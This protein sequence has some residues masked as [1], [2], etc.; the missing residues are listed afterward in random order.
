VVDVWPHRE[1]SG[2]SVIEGS[3]APAALVDDSMARI[4][5]EPARAGSGSRVA[6]VAMQY[7]LRLPG[8]VTRALR[9]TRDI[10]V[11]MPDGAVLLADHWVPSRV[12]APLPTV[13]LRSPYG[14]AGVFDGLF[15]RPFAERGFQVVIQSCRGTYGSGGEFV[16]FRHE[17]ADGATTI[18]WIAEQ[19]WFDGTLVL[20][21]SSYLGFTALANADH[22]E[23]NALVVGVT[24]ASP[25]E[26][27]SRPLADGLGWLAHVAEQERWG[28]VATLRPIFGIGRRRLRKSLS[29]LPLADADRRMIGRRIP[30]F[31]EFLQHNGDEAHWRVAGVD[32]RHRLEHVAAPAS[33]VAGWYDVFLPYT[34]RDYSTLVARGQ[35]PRLTVGPWSHNRDAAAHLG[36]TAREAVEWA[37]PV[38]HGGRLSSRRP[39]RLFV[40]GSKIWREF[41]SWPPPGY[42]ATTWYLQAGCALTTSVPL[43]SGR[44]RFRYDPTRPTPSVGGPLLFGSPGRKQN[45]RLEARPDVLTY[46][47][48][49]LE[50]DVEVVGYPKAFIWMTSSQP[51]T[52]LFVRL[53]DV[54]SRG[55]SSNI[56]D[57]ITTVTAADAVDRDGDAVR[58]AVDIWP[59]AHS[60]RR[61][62]RIRVQISSGAHPRFVRHPGGPGARSTAEVLHPADQQIF[63]GSSRASCVLLPTLVNGGHHIRP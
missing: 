41:E 22:P 42:E 9:V 8:P 59:T 17:R 39:V 55:R 36:V 12:A 33:I 23:V 47:S 34:L 16:P 50:A 37:L 40:M 1:A 43:D 19:P 18:E 4:G 57:G 32:H 3:L 49:P 13:L 60:F 54:D 31:Q 21:G 53:C 20:A 30:L 62:H 14:R 26:V 38:V 5:T 7:A 2:L 63:H 48:E 24:S 35:Q 11:E 45:A 10:P 6:S 15:Y 56:C 28:A 52:D 27:L 51:S 29:E 61:G 58:V 44:D 25:V 46:S